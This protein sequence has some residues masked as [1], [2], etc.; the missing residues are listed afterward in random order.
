MEFLLVQAIP[1]VEI[2]IRIIFRLPSE[3][4]ILVVHRP[5]FSMGELMKSGC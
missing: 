2:S 1:L 3:Q 5:I 4:E